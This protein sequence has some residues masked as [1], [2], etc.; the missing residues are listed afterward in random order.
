[1]PSD[2]RIIAGIIQKRIAAGIP[3]GLD[4]AVCYSK[5]L[6]EPDRIT[7]CAQ[8]VSSDYKINSAYN[9][10]LH[11]GLPPGPIGN[12]GVSSIMAAQ[13]PASSPYWYYLSDLKTGDTIFAETL[14]EH[15]A[16]RQK[17]L[18]N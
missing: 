14:E 12:P 10:Y 2:Q 15:A 3:L 5:Q 4:A 9:T 6:G 17:H 8:L 13:S 11:R 18:D 1:M 7:N 16:N